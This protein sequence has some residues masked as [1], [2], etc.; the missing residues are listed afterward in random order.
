MAVTEI[1]LMG[2]KPDI[3]VMDPSRPEGT[4]IPRTYQAV[5]AHPDGPHRASW[6]LDTKDPL[7]IWVFFDFD[8]VEHHTTFAKRY[9]SCD[10][11]AQVLINVLRNSPKMRGGNRQGPPDHPLPRCLHEARGVRVRLEAGSGFAPE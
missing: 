9:V 10:P 2:V 1:G 3:D 11:I 8:S 5:T 4:V 7:K 6:G